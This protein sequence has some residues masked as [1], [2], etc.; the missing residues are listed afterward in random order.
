VGLLSI[1][2]GR[3]AKPAPPA[4]DRLFALATAYLTL[5]ASYQVKPTGKAAVVVQPLNTPEFNG[6]WQEAQ[7]LVKATAG[8]EQVALETKEDSFGY[9]WLVLTC[10]A[11]AVSVEGLVVAANAVSSTLEGAGHG[12]RLL[13]ATFGFKGEGGHPLYLIYNFK[14]GRWYPFAPVGERERDSARELEL[15][16]QL[17]GELPVEE[18][19][20]RW[21][22]LWGI[23][24]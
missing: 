17:A 24:I 6:V 15:K 22:P 19:I 10:A 20:G 21:F 14:R 8:E 2:T 5:E 16:G 11:G 13:C 1:L 12:E 18:E 9:R 23:P 4:A 7:E 3:A